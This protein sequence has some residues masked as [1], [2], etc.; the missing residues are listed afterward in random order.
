MPCPRGYCCS[1]QSNP[2]TD[3]NTCENGR[4]G[5]LCGTCDEGHVQAF[6]SDKCIPAGENG[7]NL[8]A[9]IVYFV[10][11]SLTYTTLFIFLP[12]IVEVVKNMIS[13][14]KNNPGDVEENAVNKTEGDDENIDEN[15]TDEEP[16]PISAFVTIVIFY[17]QIA[18][19][20]HVDV[21]QRNTSG[22]RQESVSKINKQIFDVFNF[23]FSLY[24]ELCPADNLTLIVKLFINI[25]MKMNIIFNLMWFYIL[26]K[27][28][29]LITCRNKRS[30]DNKRISRND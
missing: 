24:Q 7:C 5:V 1:T 10:I 14:F 22:S 23:R 15:T 28:C 17:F 6:M 29:T 20:V 11:V 13:R 12:K 21:I 8:I 19:L 4:T 26:W 30:V 16:L 18:S 27:C 2:C 9:F 25:G 3:Y